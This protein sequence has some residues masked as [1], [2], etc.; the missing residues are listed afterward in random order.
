MYPPK[1]AVSGEKTAKGN[2]IVK[3]SPLRNPIR[4][5]KGVAVKCCPRSSG[6]LL[7]TPSIP[8]ETC[9]LSSKPDLSESG[10]ACLL[11]R[12]F[13]FRLRFGGFGKSYLGQAREQCCPKPSAPFFETPSIL[14][15]T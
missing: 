15:G 13:V 2:A 6:S 12:F 11:P 9:I 14:C 8:P 5:R 4:Q 3:R 1:N 7:E 10:S